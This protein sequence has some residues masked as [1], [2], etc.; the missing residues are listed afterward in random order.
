M[1]SPFASPVPHR[2]RMWY[3][4]LADSSGIP[5]G[6]KPPEDCYVSGTIGLAYVGTVCQMEKLLGF[7]ILR[8]LTDCCVVNLKT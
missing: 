3:L 7:S 1:P 8:V 6:C 5:V 4:N 2:F